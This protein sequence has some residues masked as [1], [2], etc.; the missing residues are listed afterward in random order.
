MIFFVLQGAEPCKL[1]FSCI[2]PLCQS[3]KI[4]QQK[5]LEKRLGMGGRKKTEYFST[6]LC[7]LRQH[8]QTVSSQWFHLPLC[9][10]GSFL[11]SIPLLSFILSPL[12]VTVDLWV[13]SVFHVCTFSSPKAY[14]ISSLNYI[15][16]VEL[17]GVILFFLTGL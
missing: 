15:S 9:G 4:G 10:F 13:A 14:G 11:V 7:L 6:F 17:F 3:M 5:A 16:S 1:F 2:L 8:V 12:R